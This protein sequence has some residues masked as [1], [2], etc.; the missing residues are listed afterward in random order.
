[1]V[2]LEFS[3]CIQ[4]REIFSNIYALKYHFLPMK[5]FLNEAK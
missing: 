5:K 1:V 4:L 3:N 2:S